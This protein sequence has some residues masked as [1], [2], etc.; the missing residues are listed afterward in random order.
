M[1]NMETQYSQIKLNIPI[2]L[3]GYLATRAKNFGIPMASY[4]KYLI[5]KDIEQR[6]Y[7]TFTVSDKAIKAYKKSLQSSSKALKVTGEIGEFLDS[8]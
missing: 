1:Y 7:P 4:M 6:D 3:K 2:E 5:M 8:Q